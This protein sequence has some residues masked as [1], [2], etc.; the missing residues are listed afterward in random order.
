MKKKKSNL[1]IVS[2]SPSILQI[3]PRSF[4][5]ILISR[6]NVP[7]SFPFAV[8]DLFQLKVVEQVKRKEEREEREGEREKKREKRKDGEAK[9]AWRGK[10]WWWW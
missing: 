3:F 6:I 7:P 2:L 1:I 9:E 4:R 5:T 8:E 10:G